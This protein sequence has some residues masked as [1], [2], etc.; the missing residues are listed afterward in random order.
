MSEGDLEDQIRKALIFRKSE[1][2]YRMLMQKPKYQDIW[3]GAIKTAMTSYYTTLEDEESL[4]RLDDDLE[5]LFSNPKMLKQMMHQ[6]IAKCYIPGGE[7]E[8]I[9]DIWYDRLREEEVE[10]GV[11]KKLRAAKEKVGG[12]IE[13]QDRIV[14]D[15]VE[16]AEEKGIERALAEETEIEVIRRLIPSVNEFI[17]FSLGAFQA[18]REYLAS[19]QEAMLLSG[20]AGLDIY[21]YSKGLEKAVEPWDKIVED[22]IY[23]RARRVYGEGCVEGQ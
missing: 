5:V 13:L 1:E 21:A 20:E 16:I 18:A 2:N 11:I 15:L 22:A 6:S 9:F 17:K 8:A 12:Y 3:K 10:E 7:I 4:E 23:E 14:G 19:V